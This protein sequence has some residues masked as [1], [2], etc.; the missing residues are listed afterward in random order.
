MKGGIILI[1]V[2]KFV[3][4]LA[5]EQF[6]GDL[7]VYYNRA[8]YYD[9]SVGRFT[10]MDE[11]LGVESRPLSLH[12][13]FYAECNPANGIDPSGKLTITSQQAA[14]FGIGTLGLISINQYYQQYLSAS[15]LSRPVLLVL[16]DKV[17]FDIASINQGVVGEEYT[18]HMGR[19]QENE[20]TRQAKTIAMEKDI[21]PCEALALIE[22][23]LEKEYQGKIP[24]VIRRK[25]VQA[26]KYFLGCRNKDK[27]RRR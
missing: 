20:F 16:I 6:D 13:Y 5:G 10:Q 21:D 17:A 23:M 24:G 12:K 7:G 1:Q 27:D 26:E 18:W 15:E 3:L 25:F 9:Q 8:R 22:S 2:A 4:P 19:V 11:W 14:M